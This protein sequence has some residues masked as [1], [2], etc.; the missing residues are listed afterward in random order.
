MCSSDL[1]IDKLIA[2][3]PAKFGRYFEPFAGGA[4]LFFA[5]SARG[6][7]SKAAILGESNALLVNAY[8]QVKIAVEPLIREL[9]KLK[10]DETVYYDVRETFPMGSPVMR[11]AQLIYLN[12]ACFNGLWRVNKKGKFN[13]PFGKYANP[14]ICD[15]DNLRRVSKALRTT[16]LMA[17]DF[18]KVAMQA[19]AGD[20]VY[21]DP[22]YWPADS[23]Y[24]DFTE[25]NKEPFGP[26]E[27]ERLRDVALM[28]KKRGVKVLLSN[29]D[30]EPVRKLYARGFNVHHIEAKR[31]I[32]SKVT[33]RGN[34]GELLIT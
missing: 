27:Q 25:Y 19:A 16:G 9:G 11:A 21:F 5:L 24:G 3:V 26:P 31:A 15:A 23:E 14:T 18:E 6:Y 33:R 32:N 20:F 8:T 13:V 4:A 34:V 30:V 7:L 1:I 12:R 29:A 22:P 2:H 28:L 10:Y 17:A